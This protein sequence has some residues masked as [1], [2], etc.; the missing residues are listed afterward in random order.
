[1]RAYSTQLPQNLRSYCSSEKERGKTKGK[2][3]QSLGFAFLAL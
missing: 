2:A 1:L 3:K